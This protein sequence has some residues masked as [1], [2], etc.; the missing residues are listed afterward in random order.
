MQENAEL[1]MGRIIA[2]IM[3]VLGL[4]IWISMALDKKRARE[5]GEAA[6]SLGFESLAALPGEV[7]GI[8]GSSELM[9]TGRQR[10]S[11]N[12]FRRSVEPLDVFLYDFRW[13]VGKGKSQQTSVQTIAMFRSPLLKSPELHLK[14]EGWLS[15]VGEMFGRVDIDFEEAPEFSRMFTLSGHDAPAIREFMTS[16]RLQTL[17]E[18]KGF[19]IEATHGS[20]LIWINGKRTPPAELSQFFERSF[21]VYSAFCAPG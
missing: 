6:A 13:T 3:M 10:V 9:N 7:D 21:I 5:M 17:T 14:P 12:V 8:L 4:I 16:E 20:L 18:L 11:N 1:L 15:K 19:S 2:G